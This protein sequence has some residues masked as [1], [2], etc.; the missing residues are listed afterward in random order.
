MFDKNVSFF[1]KIFIIL[2]FVYILSPFDIIPDPILG[3]GI[4]DDITL[5]LIAYTFYKG[6]LK[7]YEDQKI[8]SKNKEDIIHH[9]DYT[10]KNK[11]EV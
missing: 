4:I 8:K 5:L 9:V 10:V 7:R 2:V 3:F 1:K 6:E 11:E